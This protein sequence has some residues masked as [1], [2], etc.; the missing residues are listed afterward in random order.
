MQFEL[1]SPFEYV[2]DSLIS[3]TKTHWSLGRK[4]GFSANHQTLFFDNPVAFAWLHFI[5]EEYNEVVALIIGNTSLIYITFLFH[6]LLV[7]NTLI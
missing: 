1:E 5:L 4:V 2:Y 6:G 7:S 3:L